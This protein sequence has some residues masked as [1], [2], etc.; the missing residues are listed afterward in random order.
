MTAATAYGLLAV[1]ILAEIT[2]TLALKAADGLSRIGPMAI[3]VVG[4]ALSFWLLSASLQRFPVALV[5]S[6]WAGFG[7]VGVAVGGWWLFGETLAPPALVG[8]GAIA[9]G[10]FILAKAMETS[11]A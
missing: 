9:L 1:A 11:P 3:V 2:A 10:V 4:Y 8:I 7:M 6:V 5:Y